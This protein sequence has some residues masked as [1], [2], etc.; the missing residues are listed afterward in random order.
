MLSLS[1]SRSLPLPFSL[2]PSLRPPP[3]VSNMLTPPCSAPLHHPVPFVV[4]TA[5]QVPV[6]VRD[7]RAEVFPLDRH[8]RHVRAAADRGRP[9]GCPREPLPQGDELDQPWQPRRGGPRRHLTDSCG[10]VSR[11]YIVALKNILFFC[12][13]LA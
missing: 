13:I 11:C 2:P 6:A 4:S 1:R 9:A 8:R 7:A 12:G 10:G 5:A 3:S